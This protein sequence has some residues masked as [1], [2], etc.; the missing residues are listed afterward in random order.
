MANFQLAVN[1]MVTNN[2]ANSNNTPL[3]Q[4]GLPD[5]QKLKKMLIDRNTVPMCSAYAKILMETLRIEPALEIGPFRVNL[6]VSVLILLTGV[7]VLVM[8]DRRRPQKL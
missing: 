1:A 6:V 3:L 8:S 5:T 2:T 4:R 7:L